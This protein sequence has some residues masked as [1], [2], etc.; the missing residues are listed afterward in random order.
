MKDTRLQDNWTIFDTK[1]RGLI[2]VL[3]GSRLSKAPHRIQSLASLKLFALMTPSQV[4]TA[5]DMQMTT[6]CF[7]LLVIASHQFATPCPLSTPPKHQYCLLIPVTLFK[8]V[9]ENHNKTEVEGGHPLT[10]M[11]G[12]PIS[13]INT[14]VTGIPESAPKTKTPGP[15][16]TSSR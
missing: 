3:T 2:T 14:D 10:G 12:F 5:D 1:D 13:D 8:R 6:T 16:G 9:V 7:S 4:I 11:L 15:T